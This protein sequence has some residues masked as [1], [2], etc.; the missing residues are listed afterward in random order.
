MILIH[1]HKI[2]KIPPT[3]S[4]ILQTRNALGRNLVLGIPDK[5]SGIPDLYCPS[6]LWKDMYTS[7]YTNPNFQRQH[8]LSEQA[9][10][11]HFKYTYEANGWSIF[12]SFREHG[13]VP[14]PYKVRKFKDLS[15]SRSIIS[16]F[17]HPLKQVFFVAAAGL[18][19]CLKAVDFFHSNLFNPTQA[20]PTMKLLFMQL[21]NKFDSETVFNTWVADVKEIYDWLPQSDILRAIKWILSY[22]AKTSRRAS[23]TVFYKCTK[24]SRIGKSYQHDESVNI[25]FEDIYKIC[26]FE[27]KNAYFI[28]NNVVFL[29]LHGCPQGGI[30]SPGSSMVVCVFYEHQFRCSIYDY[31]AFIFFF[32]YFDD[33]RAVVVHRS[34]SIT[35]KSLAS[36]L[37]HQLQNDTYHPSMSLVLEECSQN[38][39][40]FLEGKFSIENDSLSCLWT[41]KNFESLLKFGKLKFFTSQDYFSYT[42][43]KKKVIRLA[44]VTGRLSA[45]LGYSFT[46]KDIIQSFGY[47]LVDLFARNYPKKV[48]TILI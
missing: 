37:L 28:L 2:S 36:S 18:M 46:D 23:V 44:T 6:I 11:Q 41:S 19:T 10:L 45:L 20:L 31:L 4:Q 39:F 33:L 40:K 35:S 5:N 38:T 32:R 17:H 8:H 25:S 7:F 22:I 24:K 21:H 30:G 3:C 43:D 1:F 12:G 48:H 16:Y 27:I 29:Q 42:G 47:L 13:S 15:R 9:V 34:S 14:Y 26:A